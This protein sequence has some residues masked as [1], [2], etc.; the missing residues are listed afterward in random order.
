[1]T[2]AVFDSTRQ[3]CEAQA[4]PVLH[5]VIPVVEAADREVRP[6]NWHSFHRVLDVEPLDADHVRVLW[7][8]EDPWPPDPSTVFRADEWVAAH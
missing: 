3:A 6:A 2:A 1:M 8:C 7:C 5:T 4:D